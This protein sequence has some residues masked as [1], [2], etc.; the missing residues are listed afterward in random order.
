MTFVKTGRRRY[1]A[2]FDIKARTKSEKARKNELR[3]FLRGL[4]DLAHRYRGTVK[5]TQ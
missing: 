5:E 4:K 2:L 1:K 3:R